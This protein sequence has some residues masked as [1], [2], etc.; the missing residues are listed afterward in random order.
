MLVHIFNMPVTDVGRFII[1]TYPAGATILKISYLSTMKIN[2]NNDF[3]FEKGIYI[4]ICLEHVCI[5]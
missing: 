1:Y 2:Q 5:I 4:Y 3:I